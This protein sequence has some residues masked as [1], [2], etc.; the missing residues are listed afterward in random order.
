MPVVATLSPRNYLVAG[1]LRQGI[2]AKTPEKA[3]ALETW[4]MGVNAFTMKQPLQ[5]K[6]TVWVNF[7]T[8]RQQMSRGLVYFNLT[9]AQPHALSRRGIIG[10]AMENMKLAVQQLIGVTLT[11]RQVAA[12][13]RYEQ[14]LM[15]WNERF[16]LTAIRDV[17]GIR[18]KH[19]L[20]SLS[21]LLVLKEP[22]P[23]RLMDIGTGAGFP[24]IPLKLLLPN[25]KL[26]LVESVGKKAEFCRH[27]VQVLKLDAVEVLQ[28]R[29]EELGLDR[30]HRER[31]DWVVARAVAGMPVLAEYLLPLARV[32]GAILAQK[33]ESGP[34]EVN[35]AEHAFQMLG[36][37]VR[38]LLKINLPGIV[39]DRYLIVVDKTAATP[40]GY[41]RRVGL[42][43]KKPIG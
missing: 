38:K 33:G 6:L 18:T 26:T 37:K 12:F 25:L 28:A 39:E 9:A 35:A 13:E 22:Q 1:T 23:N 15:E 20:D 24:G 5:T 14:E 34:A 3:L 2:P 43:L 8:K 17:E 31:Y 21:C 16:N 27:M 19:F 30:S 36:G 29:A 11:A 42:P 32:G 4:G 7:T 10:F 41:P 40:P